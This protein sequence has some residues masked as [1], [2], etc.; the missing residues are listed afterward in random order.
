MVSRCIA[1]RS[2][3]MTAPSTYDQLSTFDPD[4]HDAMA[5][6]ARGR[7]GS[8]RSYLTWATDPALREWALA[9]AAASDGEADAEER[10]A[11]VIRGRRGVAA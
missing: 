4:H 6:S 3:G 1:D 8:F 11:Q 7:A 9:M 5:E 2:R 10:F